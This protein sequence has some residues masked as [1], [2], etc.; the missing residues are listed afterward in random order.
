MHGTV[1]I[2]P[3][4][5]IPIYREKWDAAVADYK[6]DLVNRDFVSYNEN[7][8]QVKMLRPG[9]FVPAGIDPDSEVGEN[10]WEIFNKLAPS[11]T[12]FLVIVDENGTAQ[13]LLSGG[14][15]QAKFLNIGS[16]NMGETRLWGG[17]EPMTGKG[18]AVMNDPNDRKFVVYND[19]NNYVE[20]F[21]REDE[22]GLKGVV[23]GNVDDPVFSLGKKYVYDSEAE[24]WGWK[25][26]N[27]IGGFEM[28]NSRIGSVFGSGGVGE[29]MSL[30]DFVVKF[31]DESSNDSRF[32]AIGTK[33]YPSSTAQATLLRLEVNRVGSL[34]NTLA[35]LYCSGA[36]G[37]LGSR[38]IALK[39][40]KGDLDIDDGNFIVGNGYIKGKVA[41]EVVAGNF[42]TASIIP[43]LRYFLHHSTG[44]VSRAM[45]DSWGV[46]G[47]VLT[48]V[49]C[50]NDNYN[51]TLT[52]IWQFN[53]NGGVTSASIEM[54]DGGAEVTLIKYGGKWLFAGRSGN[55]KF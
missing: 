38:N 11:A 5:V 2:R 31:K 47:Q 32:A 55:A 14:R 46:T 34:S 29:G 41:H 16:L 54:T 51:L 28:T 30:Y 8:Y 3:K 9:Q 7:I 35:Y 48:I 44:N 18:L 13:T 33:V 25:D 22:W 12:N 42:S 6:Y 45:S 10:Y 36:S 23:E 1:T 50:D 37:N 26:N 24:T 39:I 43:N 15:I 21:Q 53:K 49:N 17:A 52:N 20:M 27:K 40:A 4:E 19:A